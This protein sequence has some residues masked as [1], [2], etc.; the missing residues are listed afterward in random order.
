M[1]LHRRLWVIL[2]VLGCAYS[3]RISH[4]AS[5]ELRIDIT[6][7]CRSILNGLIRDNLLKHLLNLLKASDKLMG[8]HRQK[9]VIWSIVLVRHVIWI[10][11]SQARL[12]VQLAKYLSFWHFGYK[13]YCLVKSVLYSAHLLHRLVHLD[14]FFLDQVTLVVE[15]FFLGIDSLAAT[16]E[17]SLPLFQVAFLVLDL[18]GLSFKLLVDLVIVDAFLSESSILLYKVILQV[19]KLLS[20]ILVLDL[21]Q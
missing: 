1:V 21:H 19:G 8:L 3:R 13:L 17:R 12:I 15:L 20:C 9:P 11:L 14:A 18:L 4:G 6:W 7:A 2:L 5:C 10:V 16:F